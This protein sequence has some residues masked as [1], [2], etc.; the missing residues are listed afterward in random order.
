MFVGDYLGGR[1]FNTDPYVGSGDIGGL[2]QLSLGDILKDPGNAIPQLQSNLMNNWQGILIGSTLT[3]AS[4]KIAR[5]VLR[6]PLA[7][8]NAGIFGKRGVLGPIGFKL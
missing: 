8:I 3:A 4:F 2:T 5:R 1:D 7:K 6:R